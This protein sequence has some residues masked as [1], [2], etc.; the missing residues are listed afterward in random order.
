M[1]EQNA[2]KS[3][4]VPG[5]LDSLAT[6]RRYVQAAA[7]Q[8]H[9]EKQQAYRLGLAVDELATNIVTY[10]YAD[11]AADGMIAVQATIDVRTLK[12]TLEDTAHPFDPTQQDTPA[13]LDMPLDERNIGGLGIFLALN[14]IDDFTYERVDNRNRNT[15]VV[16]R[17]ESEVSA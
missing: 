15:L 14:G 9:L 13:D 3:L 7:E 12:I 6:I 5:E 17:P 4:V 10:G 16:Y 2:M 8:A 1:D 11:S